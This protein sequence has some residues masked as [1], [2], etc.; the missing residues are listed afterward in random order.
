MASDFPTGAGVHTRIKLCGMTRSE[1]VRLA[2]ALGVDCIGLIF[3]E[4]SQRRLARAQAAALRALVP[5]SIRVV[6]LLM[7]TP[8]DEVARIVATV[9]PDGLQFHGSE[10][11]DRCAA[12]GLPYFKAVAMADAADPRAIMARFPS[13]FGFVLDGH[14]AG[15]AGGSGRSFD[16]SRLPAASAQPIL[17][18]GGLTPANVGT[19]VRQARPWGVDVSS[20]IESAPGVKDADAMRAFVAAVRAAD[21]AALAAIG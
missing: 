12:F 10:S 4:R 21:A 7:D 5:A 13:A 17:L 6:A 15:E 1:D 16:W 20:G 11:A 19:A 18:A 2:V 9:R 3:A 14:A 8:E